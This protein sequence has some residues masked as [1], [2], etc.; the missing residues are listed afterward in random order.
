[1]LDTIRKFEIPEGVDLE[2]RLAGPVIRINAW[3]IDFII[4]SIIQTA[5]YFVL[6]WLGSIG[7]GL[8]LLTIFIVEWFYP[9]LFELYQGATPGKKAL[10]LYVC[11]DDGTPVNW[12]SSMLRNLL[13]V[14]DFLPFAYGLGLLSMFINRDFKRLG[15]LAAGTVVVYR[16][17]KSSKTNVPNAKPIPLPVPLTITEQRSILDFAE[18]HEYLSIPRQ[19]ELSNILES[20]TGKQND[21]SVT[22]LYKYANWLIKGQ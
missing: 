13:R 12:Q 11:H 2:L 14:A 5:A 19:Q 21:A 22:E 7:W 8:I 3:L 17:T 18:R 20:L 15:D 16:D 6:V 1:M 10:N 9:V 4:R